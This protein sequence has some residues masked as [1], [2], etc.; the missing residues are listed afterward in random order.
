MSLECTLV[1]AKVLTVDGWSDAPLSMSG[2]LISADE[3]GR[4]IDLSGYLVLP[5]IVDPHGDGFERHMAP[6]RGALREAEHG[7]VA[8]AAEL[9]ANGITTAVLAQFFSWE[10]GMRGPDFAEHV[11]QSVAA[12]RDSV[13]VDLQLQLRLETHLLDDFARAEAAID[14]FGIGYVVFNDHLPHQRLSEGRKPPR[15]TGQAL[16]SGR[17]PEA[18]LALMQDLH[19]RSSDVPAALDALTERLVQKGIVLGS[20][21]DS[22]P[23]DREEWAVRGAT[24][25]EF[26]ETLE[27]AQAARDDGA[28]I[29]LGAPNVVRGASHAGNIAASELVAHGLCDALASD[30][31]YPSPLR[32]AFRLEE[33]GLCDL[34][35]AWAMLSS[36]PAQMLGLADRGTLQPGKRADLIVVDPTTRRVEATIA[37]GR[38]AH[39]TGTV[40]E[41]FLR[42]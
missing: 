33:L 31:H 24:V 25:S 9:A 10:G 20:H 3:M 16:K 17:S 4:V 22:T 7:V 1:G 11:F 13:A 6:R 37:A 34:A 28:Q 12:V 15:L 21:D 29:V 39:L 30:Y 40:A 18:H 38:V 2:G 5:G 41:R 36:G 8:V 14:R 23:E 19:A 35:S 42:S 26:P 32:A 27:A